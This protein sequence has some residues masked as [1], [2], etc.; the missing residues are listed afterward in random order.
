MANGHSYAALY[1]IGK[2]WDENQLVVERINRKLATEASILHSVMTTAI[3]AFGK[4]GGRK[5]NKALT[6]LIEGLN[7]DE[8]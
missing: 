5:A 1:P 4:D 2:L 8:S 6:K 3:A 7:G